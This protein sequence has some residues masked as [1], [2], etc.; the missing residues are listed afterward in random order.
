MAHRSCFDFRFAQD[1]CEEGDEDYFSDA[2][3]ITSILCGVADN[4]C[5]R[6]TDSVT[7]VLPLFQLS[8]QQVRF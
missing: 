3:D 7:K 4:L 2:K 6:G 1:S 5:D 8:T